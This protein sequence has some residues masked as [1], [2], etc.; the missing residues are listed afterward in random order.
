MVDSDCLPMSVAV[1]SKRKVVGNGGPSNT[2]GV[3]G[4]WNVGRV[5]FAPQV[6]PIGIE[7]RGTC[8]LAGVTLSLG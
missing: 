5:Q 3:R 8:L 4:S 2:K 6:K 7:N 1:K